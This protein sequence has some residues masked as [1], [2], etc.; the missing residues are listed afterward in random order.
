[1]DDWT[2]VWHDVADTM[3]EHRVAGRRH[4]LTEDSLRMATVLA[5]ERSGVSTNDLAIEVADPLLIGGKLDLVIGPAEARTVIEIKY[6]RG[7]RTGVSPDT[8]T[9]GELLRDFLRVALVPAWDRWVVIALGQDL[10]RYLTRRGPAL[11]SDA[12]GKPF[13][14]ERA[15]LELL[16]KTALD[17]IGPLA[18]RL[19]VRA[20]CAASIPI[21]VDL[22]FFAFRIE[23]PTADAASGALTGRSADAI[24][25]MRQPRTPATEGRVTGRGSARG[26]IIAAIRALTTRAGRSEVTVQ[27]VVDEMRRASSTYAESTVRT[28]LTS[29]MCAQIHG[30]NIGSYDD[31]DRVGR[32]TYRLRSTGQSD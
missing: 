11:W 27:E 21:D 22:G 30:P 3:R 16:P 9:H 2:A 4:L 25:T 15:A 31:V 32:G 13:V 8:M 14:L 28:M 26:E 6:P 10:R 7:S 5:L 17:G 24:P 23:A 1:M 12:V 29:H 20:M 18:Y 19:P